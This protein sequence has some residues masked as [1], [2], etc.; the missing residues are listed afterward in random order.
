MTTIVLGAG[1]VGT[2]T[3]WY[4]M[5]AGH[6]VVVARAPGR[7]RHGDELGQWR[8]HPCERGRAL[9]AARHAEQ[10]PA[11]GWARRTRRCSCA[12][13]RSRICG[14]GVST[15]RATA[16]RSG[17][18]RMPRPISIWRCIRCARCRRSA[19][20]PASL[21]TAPR[22]ASQDLP[23]ARGARRR[24]ALD[25][26]PGAARPPVSARRRPAMRRARTGPARHA[27][28]PRRRALFRARRGRRLQQV[29]PGPC[30]GI[31]RRRRPAS[32]SARRCKPSRPSAARSAPWSRT[33]DR[34]AAD[35]IVV[36]MG[37]FTAPLLAT[38]GIRVPIYPVKGV[39]ITFP[40]RRVEQRARHA[41]DRRQQAVRPR[42][43]RRAHAHLRLGRD[44]RL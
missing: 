1:A 16:R 28:H 32:A 9:V 17:S 34:I 42:A 20:R 13:A 11:N 26:L 22:G 19:P 10:D 35:T 15:S 21:M 14:A 37:S 25:R 6:D 41:G 24:G 2:A 5:K 27:R 39:S 38:I 43:D 7:S 12:T 44:H 4:L 30:I 3:A 29:H 8:R 40:A 36:A 18:G 33:R 31:R 23:H